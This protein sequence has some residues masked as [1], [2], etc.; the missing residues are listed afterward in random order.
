MYRVQQQHIDST[1]M[2]LLPTSAPVYGGGLI[3]TFLPE[4]YLLPDRIRAFLVFQGAQQ[5]QVTEAKLSLEDNAFH[6]VIPDHEPPEHVALSAYVRL[7][8]DEC[9]CI[10]TEE[11]TY[12]LDQTCYLARY[13]ADSVNNLDNLEDW[14]KIQGPN[15]SLEKEDFSTLDERL[16]SAFQHLILPPNWSLSGDPGTE[17]IPRETLFH[18][19][20]RLGLSS[21]VTLLLEKNG[22]WGC[23]KLKNRH[24]ELAKDIAR[25]RGFDGLADLL[26]DPHAHGVIKWEIKERIGQAVILKR[27]S[28]GTVSTSSELCNGVW[29]PLVDEIDALS[30][31][32]IPQVTPIPYKMDSS[33]DE[34]EESGRSYYDDDYL[35][36][37]YS[38]HYPGAQTVPRNL[39]DEEK[40]SNLFLTDNLKHLQDISD[41][42]HYLRHKDVENLKEAES[43]ESPRLSTSCPDLA[44]QNISRFSDDALD[45]DT[46]GTTVAPRNRRALPP[47]FNEEQLEAKMLDADVGS[48]YPRRE[49]SSNIHQHQD[50]WPVR[51]EDQ[52]DSYPSGEPSPTSLQRRH[53]WHSSESLTE[54]VSSP[55]QKR[56]FSFQ[57]L[58]DDEQE[59][60]GSPAT[61]ETS[62]VSPTVIRRAER[63]NMAMF[64]VVSPNPG[65]NDKPADE[66]ATQD[67]RRS[68]S[69]ISGYNKPTATRNTEPDRRF[70]ISEGLM[71]GDHRSSIFALQR[72]IKHQDPS[73]FNSGPPPVPPKPSRSEAAPAKNIVTRKLSFLGKMRSSGRT[74]PKEKSKKTWAEL[75]LGSSGKLQEEEEDT[76]EGSDVSK[77]QNK[78]RPSIIRPQSMMISRPPQY[79]VG[80]PATGY[81]AASQANQRSTSR[82]ISVVGANSMYGNSLQEFPQNHNNRSNRSSYYEEEDGGSPVTYSMKDMIS[83]SIE[84]LDEASLDTA[85]LEKDP[86][87][88][89]K[90]DEPET[91]STTI[92]RKTLK[93]M[94]KK[95]IKR[96][97][98]IFEFI[99]TERNYLTILKIMQKIYAQ[100]LLR[101]A[102]MSPRVVDQLFPLIDE[103][104]DFVTQFVHKL[105]DRQ[106]DSKVVDRIGDLLVAQWRNE[107]GATMKRLLG[108]FCSHQNEIT[109]LYK[110]LVKTDKKVLAFMKKCDK[111]PLTRRQDVP[112]CAL[113][114]TQRITKYPIMLQTLLENTI[115]KGHKEDHENLERALELSREIAKDV[116]DQVRAHEKQQLLKEI[117]EKTE[118]KSAT[119]FKGNRKFDRRDFKRKNRKLVYSSSTVQWNI[120][121][122]KK[123]TDVLFLVLS[124]CIVFLQEN[125]G[126]YSFP[127][128]QPAAVSLHKLIVREVAY[129]E[130]GL[131]LMSMSSQQMYKLKLTSINDC[132]TIAQVLNVAIPNCPDDDEGVSS[133]DEEEKRLHER[134][135]EVQTRIA[136][137]EEKDEKIN[138]LLIE[139]MILFK[140]LAESVDQGSA[141]ANIHSHIPMFSFSDGDESGNNNKNL[142]PSGKPI[143]VRAIEQVSKL[144][145]AC[146]DAEGLSRHSSNV[147]EQESGPHLTPGAPKR[148]DT[149]GGLDNGKEPPSPRSKWL[150]SSQSEGKLSDFEAN[151]SSSDSNRDSGLIESEISVRQSDSEGS[152]VKAWEPGSEEVASTDGADPNEGYLPPTS[153]QVSTLTSL[154]QLLNQ[155]LSISCQQDT[156]LEKLKFQLT[157]DRPSSKRRSNLQEAELKRNQLK[158][159]EQM[160]D[161]RKQ[162]QQ[163]KSEQDSFLRTRERFEKSMN[164]EKS[165]IESEKARIVRERQDAEKFK[166][167]MIKSKEY[168]QHETKRLKDIQ[169]KTHGEMH[170]SA[171]T[172]AL[173]SAQNRNNS[174]NSLSD[175]LDAPDSRVSSSKSQ[176]SLHSSESARRAPSSPTY[177]TAAEYP[178]TFP[179]PKRDSVLPPG[180]AAVPEIPLH[181]KYSATNQMTT[182]QVPKHQ[183]LSKGLS[184]LASTSKH[185]SKGSADKVGVHQMIPSKL[186]K[187]GSQHHNSS[188]SLDSLKNH[189]PF[190]HPKRKHAHTDPPPPSSTLHVPASKHSG[191]LSPSFSPLPPRTNFVDRTSSSS[192]SS[193]KEG[194]RKH[195]AHTM[196][197]P[198]E[199]VEVTADKDRIEVFL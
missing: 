151:Q 10:A 173:S 167:E 56:R 101:E 181:L 165:E 12:Y 80:N 110:E 2:E 111:N 179:F 147:G 4:D 73:N 14:D 102:H 146:Y 77:D 70:T 48:G 139:K 57:N 177:T 72:L 5:R 87:L 121:N 30:K 199:S 126:K 6:A 90:V 53:S 148:S 134:L 185:S 142:L 141:V 183:E 117:H 115:K 82:P 196:A 55:N 25:E 66:D 176:S 132:K 11:F 157:L 198:S 106:N 43:D 128:G 19:A 193:S 68:S 36:D 191:R 15:F 63:N 8:N 114:V 93:K 23:I 178:R 103:H 18:F 123:P 97:E 50:V 49:R 32:S 35:A 174:N 24:D 140:S 94:E 168:Y 52:R 96:Q 163:L 180:A 120:I 29:P 170:S 21:F 187:L 92:D 130:R 161:L 33:W 169:R 67:S 88:S 188:T 34:L 69:V 27:H 186:S 20:S 65:A 160:D 108:D 3:V 104:V 45:C 54:A 124:D 112:A 9:R 83:G 51:Q 74:K 137:L 100:G 17:H 192:S 145:Q 182:M 155:Y 16:T 60:G 184:K 22:A 127:S 89:L 26:T 59:E 189:I 129:D 84:S 61:Q 158:H 98:N 31:T 113:L 166:E 150:I 28:F 85:E 37:V 99:Q 172:S 40:D 42:I 195:R 86:D 138:R 79:A 38:Q 190:S 175:A 131:L 194:E 149:F 152:I 197:T 119:T 39:R 7:P 91:W 125:N 62:V 122:S 105:R 46:P 64:S 78:K 44:Q 144:S 153:D 109:S 41:G 71:P 75:K 58:V 136:Q 76:L 107:S 118:S 1:R 13:L 154:A 159:Q 143:L 116:D 81:P 135:N 164:A 156:L 162:Q 95:D 171:S 133:E 47:G